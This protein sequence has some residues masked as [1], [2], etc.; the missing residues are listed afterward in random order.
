MVKVLR[1]AT[2]ETFSL[3]FTAIF[4]CSVIDCGTPWT[5][6][7]PFFDADIIQTLEYLIDI[8]VEF[9]GRVFQQT[10]GIPTGIYCT[11]FLAD[12]FDTPIR[13]I[14]YKVLQNY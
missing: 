6:L 8:F 2:V 3:F 10:I 5:F 1:I 4:H 14:L 12:S 7:L 13:E 9:G 11:P